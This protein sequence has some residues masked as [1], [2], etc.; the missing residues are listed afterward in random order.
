[1]HKSA[2]ALDLHTVDRKGKVLVEN[3]MTHRAPARF[4]REVDPC[5]VG[6][7]ACGG[8]HH[9]ARMGKHRDQWGQDDTFRRPSTNKRSRNGAGTTGSG[10]ARR[11]R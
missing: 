2:P 1:M 8:A 3:K 5:L 7:E 10:Q 9:R 11:R 4:M 6:L